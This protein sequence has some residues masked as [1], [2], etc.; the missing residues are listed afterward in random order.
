VQFIS[1]CLKYD[2]PLITPQ[3]VGAVVVEACA[4][5]AQ[6]D[7]VFAHPVEAFIAKCIILDARSLMHNL[8]LCDR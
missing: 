7:A 3:T 1:S 6:V 5:Q 2:R 8:E 4:I